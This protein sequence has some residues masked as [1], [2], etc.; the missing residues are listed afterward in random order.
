MRGAFATIAFE[1]PESMVGERSALAG[2]A[3][4]VGCGSRT[5]SDPT[6][7]ARMAR[8]AEKRRMEGPPFFA[9]RRIVRLGLWRG[10]LSPRQCARASWVRPGERWHGPARW[11][12]PS[13]TD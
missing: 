10:K 12:M 8:Q 11:T 1:V 9:S 13:G 6:E 5:R 3:R 7:Q 2:V 4:A